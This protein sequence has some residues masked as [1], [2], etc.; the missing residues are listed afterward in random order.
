[1]PWISIDL[2][3]LTT[4]KAGIGR[5]SI[6]LSKHL[7]K[8][9]AFDYFGISGPETDRE[10]LRSLTWDQERHFAVRSTMI[11]SALLPFFLPKYIDL[12][13]ALDNSGILP[14]GRK[15][16]R[17]TT[18]HDVLVFLYPQHFSRK[19]RYVV[20]HLTKYAINSSDHIITV[21]ESTKNEILDLFVCRYRR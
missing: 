14:L 20:G 4:K 21:S 12:H 18:I 2:K 17:I 13:H 6:N 7:L 8:H 1:M 16:K 10:L 5:Y 11:R 9:R 15:I 3:T 19:H